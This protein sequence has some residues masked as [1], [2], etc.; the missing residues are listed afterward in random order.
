MVGGYTKKGGVVGTLPHAW[1]AAE[2]AG[3]WYLFDPTWGS[4]YIRN[5]QFVRSFNNSFYKILPTDMIKDH[6]PF[7]PMYQFLNYTV[8]NNEF[9]EGQTNINKTK[10]FFNYSDTLKH[11]ALL[12]ETEKVRDEARRL[13]ANGIQNDLILERFNHLKNGVQSNASKDKY[14]EAGI[15]F[16]QATALFKEYIEHKNKQFTTIED[17]DLQQMM[18][19]ISYQANLSRSL[20]VAV[21]PKNDAQRQ[22]LTNTYH[23]LEK[24]QSRVI[25]EK[26][27]IARYLNTDKAYRRQL[28]ARN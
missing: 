24:F 11:Y 5:Y 12:S 25:S 16:N 1:V 17:K 19:S 2:L 7:D 8:T 10:P 21:V 3:N 27:F 13:Q 15:A 28:F 23:N 9:I 26:D 14:E 20:L 22:I 4:G 6:M 18:D